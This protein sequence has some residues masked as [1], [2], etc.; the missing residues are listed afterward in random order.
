MTC[1]AFI[2]FIYLCVFSDLEARIA[3]MHIHIIVT[4]ATNGLRFHF[5]LRNLKFSTG[6][7]VFKNR[8]DSTGNIQAEKERL[9]YQTVAHLKVY[10]K[11]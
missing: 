1:H 6:G 2:L 11:Q 7:F 4:L 5:Q 9:K 3:V 8:S 10:I